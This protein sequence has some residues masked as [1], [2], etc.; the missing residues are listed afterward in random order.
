M[1]RSEND[2]KEPTDP[3]A[4]H[5]V[6]SLYPFSENT[7]ATVALVRGYHPRAERLRVWSGYI[8][9]ARSDLAGLAPVLVTR[10][11]CDALARSLPGPDGEPLA[12]TTD[13][14]PQGA[15]AS[16]GGPQGGVTGQLELPL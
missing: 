10:L 11:L 3:K 4:A 15:S 6:I 16:P 13:T 1:T 2:K 12:P 5:V 14:A 9:V 8:P 7:Q